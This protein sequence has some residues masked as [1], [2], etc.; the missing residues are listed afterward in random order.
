[1]ILPVD[2]TN[3]FKLKVE[4][5]QFGEKGEDGIAS[6]EDRDILLDLLMHASDLS[7][8]VRPFPVAKKW[9]CKSTSN[10]LLLVN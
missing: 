2:V 5:G 1:V 4:A 3:K 7:N 6:A 9:G 10:H 8:P